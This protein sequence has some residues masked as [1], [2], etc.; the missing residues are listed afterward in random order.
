MVAP[1][2]LTVVGNGMVGHHFLARLIDEGHA[3][4]WHVTTFCEEPRLAY[5]RTNLSAYFSG[6]T[7]AELSLVKPGQYS[8][9]GISVHLGDKVVAIDRR[10]R[11]VTSW[12]GHTIGYDKLVFATGAASLVPTVAGS[13]APGCFPYRTL[14]DLDAIRSHATAARVGV[15]VGGDLPGLEAASALQQL[16]LRVHVVEA[17]SRLLPRLLDDAGGALLRARIEARGVA[18]QTGKTTFA[19]LTDDD[20]CAAGLRFSDGSLLSADL[21]VFAN[22]VHARDELAR[23]GGLLVGAYG[24]IVIDERCR[25]SDPDIFAIGDCALFGD[26]GFELV[27]PGYEMAEVAVDVIAGADGRRFGGGAGGGDAGVRVRVLG[28]EV[29]SFGDAFATTA[30][31]RVI[32]FFDG[33]TAGVYKKLVLSDDGERLL[34]G[35]LVGDAGGYER[36]RG[37]VVGGGGMPEHPEELILPL[38]V[39][40]REAA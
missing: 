13:R 27:Q 17:A 37:L 10:A 12:R 40:G 22:G 5:D 29:A 4:D 20:D 35:V 30:R 23:A 19:V 11:T 21:V 25:T 36:L 16:G 14:A 1:K 18:V 28:V 6:T 33:S 8:E 39:G 9:A 2:R 38:R 3:R 34:G 31:A 26:R 24:G 32:S 7:A 15:V